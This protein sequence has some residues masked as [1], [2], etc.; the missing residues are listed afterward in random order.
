MAAACR[1]L[2]RNQDLIAVAK[3]PGGYRGFEPPSACRAGFDALQPNHPTDD[4]RALRASIL[5]GLLFGCGDAVIGINP[6]SDSVAHVERCCSL[7][8][9]SRLRFEIPTQSCVLAHVTTQLHG[10][11]ARRA[12]RSG[13]SVHRRHGSRQRAASAS[14]LL[15]WTKRMTPALA[16]PRDAS[17]RTSCISRPAR[18]ARCRRRRITA[19]TS[20]PGSARLCG[21]ARASSRC[22][23]TPSSASS[24][25]SILRRQ[26]DHPRRARRSFLRQA[27][28]PADGC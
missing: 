4:P 3:M 7:I 12:C 1:K 27:A 10:M 26:A 28:R 18:A 14:I 17:A 20:R 15:C 11:R 8:D 9:D 16:R 23:S 24:A 13:F 19:S 5:D 25:R 6:A 22:S 2:M 21:R